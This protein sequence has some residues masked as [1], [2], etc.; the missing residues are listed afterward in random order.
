MLPG[1]AFAAYFLLLGHA[2][3]GGSLLAFLDRLISAA[4]MLATWG[5]V[6]AG[7]FLL[8]VLVSGFFARVRWLAASC[9]AILSIASTFVL[10]ALGSEPFSSGRW[11]FLIPGLLSFILGGW[12]SVSERPLATR[13]HSAA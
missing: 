12:L 10:V 5:I 9:V 13:V 3:S 1:L 8:T 4:A 11:L 7:A 2:I 6:A